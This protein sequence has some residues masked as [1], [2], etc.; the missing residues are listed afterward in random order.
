MGS[1]ISEEPAAD[2]RTPGEVCGE[3]RVEAVDR[4]LC[5]RFESTRRSHWL[6]R[7]GQKQSGA[8]EADSCQS[9]RDTQ[10]YGRRAWHEVPKDQEGLSPH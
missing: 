3:R 2:V 5:R 8:I 6:R 1:E 4:E 7:Y 9:T 10:D